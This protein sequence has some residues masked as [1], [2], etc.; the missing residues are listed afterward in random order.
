MKTRIV[1][2]T[3]LLAST[4]AFAQGTPPAPAGATAPGGPG[5][6]GRPML[7][8]QHHGGPGDLFRDAD[9]N[10]DGAVSREEAQN[11]FNQ[12]FNAMDLNKDGK[13]TPEEMRS[14]REAQRKNRT[15]RFQAAMDERFKKA[16]ANGDGS[17]SREE[18]TASMPRMA[19]DF[20]RLDAN[21]DGKLTREELQNA[22]HHRG[23]QE[24]RTGM[25]P[26]RN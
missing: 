3:A 5:G 16:D 12:H 9:A 22:A 8:M 15:G 6:P 19:R 4:L 14:A 2:I 23:P 25:T 26:P 13:L 20:D 18:A 21:K 17:L 24:G 10:K 11:M 7:G 1:L